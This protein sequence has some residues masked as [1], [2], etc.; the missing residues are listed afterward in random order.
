MWNDGGYI[1]SAELL[2]FVDQEKVIWS[3]NSKIQPV[4]PDIEIIPRSRPSFSKKK[5]NSIVPKDKIYLLRQN[6]KLSLAFDRNDSPAPMFTSSRRT[7]RNNENVVCKSMPLTADD[8][9]VTVASNTEPTKSA[10]IQRVNKLRTKRLQRTCHAINTLDDLSQA[11]RINQTTSTPRPITSAN[12]ATDI[13][14]TI[15]TIR[16]AVPPATKQKT[17][18]NL[19]AYKGRNSKDNADSPLINRCRVKKSTMMGVGGGCKPTNSSTTLQHSLVNELASQFSNSLELARKMAKKK[20]RKAKK[21]LA[22]LKKNKAMQKS[23]G[24]VVN[25]RGSYRG[26]GS[27]RATT[28]RDLAKEDS[29]SDSDSSIGS[30]SDSEDE[31]KR[32]I[33]REERLAEKVKFDSLAHTNVMVKKFIKNVRMYKELKQIDQRSLRKSYHGTEVISR[34]HGYLAEQNIYKLMSATGYTRSQLYS[35]FLRFKALCAVSESP[36]GVN[37]DSF[38]S[39]LPSL[40]MEDTLF[41]DRVFD[42]IDAERRGLLDWPHYIRAMACLEQGTP[43]GRTAF[44]W[45]VYDK[46]GGGTISRSELKG[47]FV[48]SL[49]T[50]VD[51]FIED[52]AEIFVEGVFSRVRTN[53]RG[54]L[55]L[56]EA[57]KY[58]DSQDEV[59]DLH[60]MF[61]RSMAM[62]GFES[63]VDG[64][65][66][67]ANEE[68]KKEKMARRIRQLRRTQGL[69]GTLKINEDIKLKK[70]AETSHHK[71][72]L[73]KAAS[74]VQ[75]GNFLNDKILNLGKNKNLKND[76]GDD[77]LEWDLN[78]ELNDMCYHINKACKINKKGAMRRA[79]VILVREK[80]KNDGEENMAEEY[81]RRYGSEKGKKFKPSKKKLQKLKQLSDDKGLRTS[82]TGRQNSLLI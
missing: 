48:S 34:L 38:R 59:A 64:T 14:T 50:T 68:S 10:V 46:D 45:S 13:S 35:H 20:R 33:E 28:H 17:N 40:A 61:G 19:R 70:E 62:Q 57:M 30:S 63:V 51:D 69:K 3:T 22:L 77:T 27:R 66:T 71:S 1:K 54:E 16:K 25:A 55:T 74:K 24:D 4:P 43:A 6:A 21:K 9:A 12:T 32:E 7:Y 76:K 41:V 79:S 82:V 36:E 23:R 15:T 31:E 37:R 65:V 73:I 29:D 56:S 78:E 2:G 5:S 26:F 11:W 39:G 81:K 58:I 52:V 80:G 42:V 49:M 18:Q 75:Y 60:G 67:K 47:F 72:S 8:S 53:D 44:L